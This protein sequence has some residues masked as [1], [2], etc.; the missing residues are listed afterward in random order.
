[1]REKYFQQRGFSLE[2]DDEPEVIILDSFNSD[3]KRDSVNTKLNV[4]HFIYY[5]L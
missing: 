2:L 1:M 5:H 3:L 4:K